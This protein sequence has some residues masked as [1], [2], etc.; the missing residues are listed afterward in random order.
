MRRSIAVLLLVWLNACA[1]VGEVSLPSFPEARTEYSYRIL[2]PDGTSEAIVFWYYGEER[3]EAMI[4]SSGIVQI[5]T[6]IIAT[7]M[8]FARP[9][10]YIL[11]VY[12]QTPVGI[13]KQ[14]FKYAVR[15]P[16]SP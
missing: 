7:E 1:T 12:S 15:Q 10:A 11:T 9:G 5:R 6:G 14:R 16:F 3:R 4:Y 13:Q 2:L 8:Y